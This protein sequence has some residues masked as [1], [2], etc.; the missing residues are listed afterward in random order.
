M[1]FG[2]FYLADF[3]E[4]IIVACLVTTLFLGGWQ[5]PYLMPDGFHFPWGAALPV[6]SWTYVVLGVGSFSIKVLVFCWL[7]MQIRW[8]LP[9]FRYDQL[10]V[11]GWKGLFPIAV[12]NV[13]VTALA[14]VLFGGRS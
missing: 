1:K 6:S 9:R 11:L 7:F 14:L 10:M 4:T 3:L 13:L 5:V 12:A 2:M 8:T